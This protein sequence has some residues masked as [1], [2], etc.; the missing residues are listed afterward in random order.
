MKKFKANLLIFTLIIIAALF[1][2][3]KIFVGGL[4]GRLEASVNNLTKKDNESMIISNYPKINLIVNSSGEKIVNGDIAITVIAESS[5]KID[6]IHYSYD[7]E[8]W[9]TSTDFDHKKNINAKLIFNKSI[10]S[11]LYI[12]VENEKGYKSYASQTHLHIDNNK[13]KLYVRRSGSHVIINTSD[14][15]GL[16]K[17]GYS[18]DNITWDFEDLDG[19]KNTVFSKE[20]GDYLYIQVVDI[21]SNKSEIKKITD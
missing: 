3:Y 1:I 11:N 20:Y 18:K 6:K 8:K 16:E 2:S 15:S 5:Y 14:E 21:A 9:Y 10:N 4:T 13:P 12:R 7:Q 19:K 17:I